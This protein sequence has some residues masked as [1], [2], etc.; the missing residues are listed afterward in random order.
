MKG[1]GAVLFLSGY[2]VAILLGRNC[3]FIFDSHSRDSSGRK[4]VNGTAVLSK[5]LSRHHLHN[6]IERT[7]FQHNSHSL[8]FQVQFAQIKR[9]QSKQIIQISLYHLNDEE[10]ICKIVKTTHN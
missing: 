3:F 6:C 10:W 9:Y 7:Y 1:N 5:L 2:T 4:V 8:C